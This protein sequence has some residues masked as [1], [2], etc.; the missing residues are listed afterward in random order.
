MK[1]KT[2]KKKDSQCRTKCGGSSTAKVAMLVL[3]MVALSAVAFAAVS[4]ALQ[5]QLFQKNPVNWSIIDGGARGELEYGKF[6]F[7]AV[8]LDNGKSYT[9]IR[10]TD[11]WSTHQVVCLG[12][13]V[14][15]G[16]QT[17]MKVDG[18]WR[19]VNTAGIKITGTMQ[20][21]G[22]KVWLVLSSDVN[23]VTQKMTAWNPT[24]YL[25]EN[26]LIYT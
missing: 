13:S 3:G 10:Y 25:F 14:T 22:P 12:S 21:G 17:F 7:S 16:M 19:F 20:P 9:L 2:D 18:K 15:Y 24:K 5:L 23:C 1:E 11:P 4:G 26:N 8:G 6:S